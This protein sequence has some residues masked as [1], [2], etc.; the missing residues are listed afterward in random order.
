[1]GEESINSINPVALVL[2]SL[3][4][5]YF[6]ATYLPKGLLRVLSL[7]PVFYIFCV[8]PWYSS[9]SLLRGI[10]SF[11][12]TWITSFKLLLF[13]FDQG[14]L[15]ACENYMDFVLVSIFPIKIRENPSRALKSLPELAIGPLILPIIFYLYMYKDKYN[16]ELIFL[17][18][19]LGIILGFYFFFTFGA[20]L[21]TRYELLQLFKKPYL[22]TSLQDF[23]GR[24]WNRLSS[25]ILRHTIYNPTQDCLKGIVGHG[26]AKVLALI[27]TLVVS[28]IMHELMF[29][30]IT[31]G[32]KPTW[33]VTKFFVLQGVCI[34]LEAGLRY[35][36]GV[37]GWKQ[38]NPVAANVFTLG[39]VLIT[40]YWL[41][42]LPVWRSGQN[43]C[44]LRPKGFDVWSLEM[45]Y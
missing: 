16:Q 37:K 5:S 1:M 2:A 10:L 9:S 28:G 39:F 34:V 45:L 8:F 3:A 17:L 43:G 31:C 29:Y 13:C 15:I 12:I 4:Y 30:Y 33:E 32:M 18:Y 6:L 14:P 27:T 21:A 36:A 38:F 40:S 7:F 41:L 26:P 42:V 24:R 22:A 44:R 35:L 23:W 25:N 11:F 19:A 20:N